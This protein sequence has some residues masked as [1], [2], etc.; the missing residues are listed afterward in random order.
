MSERERESNKGRAR[1]QGSRKDKGACNGRLGARRQDCQREG[2]EEREIKREHEREMRCVED[3]HTKIKDIDHHT[4]VVRSLYKNHFQRHFE[5]APNTA[6][7]DN[8]K[9]RVVV[10][11]SPMT[12]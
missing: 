4:T 9:P 6:I 2:E 12:G 5:G 8:V 3:H 10:H 1:I 7:K 11:P